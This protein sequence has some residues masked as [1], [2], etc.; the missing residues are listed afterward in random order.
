MNYN[1]ITHKI[2]GLDNPESIAKEN[3]DFDALIPKFDMVNHDTILV[4]T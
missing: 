4:H 1:K 2:K 3:V